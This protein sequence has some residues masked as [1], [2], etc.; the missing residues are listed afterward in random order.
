MTQTHFAMYGHPIPP[1]EATGKLQEAYAELEAMLGSIMPH[2]QLHATHA[3]E[4]MKCFT[5]PMKLSRNHPDIPLIWFALMRL[6]VAFRDDFPYCKALNA[7]MLRGL[8]VEDAMLERYLEN[9][10]EAPLD[11]RLI[12]LLKKAIKS[13]YDSHHFDREDFEELYRAGFTDKTIY[14]AIVYSTGFSG[15]ARRLNTYL[16]KEGSSSRHQTSHPD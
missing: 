11:E 13:I 15:I 3:L 16:V 8:G 7:K 2:V 4:D 1:E 10:D 14:D 5:D 12:L 9:I 6:H